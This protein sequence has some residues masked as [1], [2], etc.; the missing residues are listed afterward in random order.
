MDNKTSYAT[1]KT[2][3]P[4]PDDPPA[5]VHT[6]TCWMTY[7]EAC[8]R[9]RV[10]ILEAENRDLFTLKHHLLAKMAAMQQTIREQKGA[11][12]K[13]DALIERELKK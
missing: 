11:L 5:H 2:F 4:A 7:Q 1:T 13:M 6:E 10:Q 12:D 3:T 9:A 8:V